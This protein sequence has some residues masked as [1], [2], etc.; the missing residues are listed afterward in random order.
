MALLRLPIRVRE[1][2]P[3]GW[4]RVRVIL[5]FIKM[6]TGF[7]HSYCSVHYAVEEYTVTFKRTFSLSIIRGWFPGHRLNLILDLKACSMNLHSE[8][9]FKSHQRVQPVFTCFTASSV[10][11]YCSV[12]YLFVD[13][14]HLRVGVLI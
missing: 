5:V 4:P 12:V 1:L 11:A 7:N 9:F 3:F 6:E 13:T 10:H 8:G 2:G 14:K